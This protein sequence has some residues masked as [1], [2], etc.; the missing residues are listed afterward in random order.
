MKRE[1]KK[2]RWEEHPLFNYLKSE[3][4]NNKVGDRIETCKGNGVIKELRY[5]YESPDMLQGFMVEFDDKRRGKQFVALADCLVDQMENETGRRGVNK[6]LTQN[7]TTRSITNRLDKL[8]GTSNIPFKTEQA[9]GFYSF[10]ES[11]LMGEIEW[12]YELTKRLGNFISDDE[13]MDDISSTIKNTNSIILK[14]I[15]NRLQRI[16]QDWED[17]PEGFKY[18]FEPEAE[19]TLWKIINLKK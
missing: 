4:E 12:S 1:S 15:Q 13:M 16:L 7:T 11:L 9:T 6:A 5:S 14:N 8:S 10:C 3:F 18:R 2:I 17:H 19:Q